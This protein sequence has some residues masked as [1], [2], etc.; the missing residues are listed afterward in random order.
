MGITFDE[1]M[2]QTTAAGCQFEIGDALINGAMQRVFVNAPPNLTAFYAAA[3]AESTFLV[4]ED[5]NYT[6]GQV[7]ETSAALGA[8]LVE[9]YGVRK[10]DRVA[11][12]MRNFPELSLI[13]I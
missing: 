5:E 8:A 1:A 2:G 10:G 6:F 4:Y 7:R 13:H 9:R 3:P 12:A 11:V